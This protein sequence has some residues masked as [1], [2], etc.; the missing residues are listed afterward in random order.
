M[1]NIIFKGKN[2]KLCQVNKYS[3]VHLYDFLVKNTSKR[4]K[5]W[6][7]EGVTNAYVVDNDGNPMFIYIYN[8]NFT[9]RKIAYAVSMN[10]KSN[11]YDIVTI[12]NI[13]GHGE[14]TNREIPMINYVNNK[15]EKWEQKYFVRSVGDFPLIYMDYFEYDAGRWINEY[16][17]PSNVDMRVKIINFIREV[18][19]ILL[20]RN[21]CFTD[22]KSDQI[23]VRKHQPGNKYH[24]ITYNGEKW[25]ICASDL[26]IDNCSREDYHKIMSDIPFWVYSVLPSSLHNKKRVVWSFGITILK[27]F[28]AKMSNPYKIM[29]KSDVNKLINSVTVSIP[30]DLLHEATKYLDENTYMLSNVK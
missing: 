25:D 24:T 4:Y 16:L 22:I 15:M 20:D 21:F 30:Q 27:I 8:N 7:N 18:L 17:P 9:H 5:L 28:G 14:D 1:S 19:K 3:D 2:N 29:S 6:D 13:R 10:R 26:D 12:K 11:S 23:L